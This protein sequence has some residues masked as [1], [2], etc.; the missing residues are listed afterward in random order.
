[1]PPAAYNT[2][3]AYDT[4]DGVWSSDGT[5]NGT[6]L[7]TQLPPDL[8]I[9]SLRRPTGRAYDD[10]LIFEALD[11]VH[12]VRQ[13]WRTDGT[14]AGTFQ[15]GTVYVE[16]R[17]DTMH[18]FRSLELLRWTD[19]RLIY[20]GTSALH[21]Q[22]IYQTDLA[23]TRSELLA[24]FTARATLSSQPHDFVTWHDHVYFLTEDVRN[25]TALWQADQDGNDVQMIKALAPTGRSGDLSA[26]QDALYFFVEEVDGWKQTLWHSDGTPAGTTP[27]LDLWHRSFNSIPDFRYAGADFVTS[28]NAL[29]IRNDNGECNIWEFTAAG[30]QPQT[31]GADLCAGSFIWGNGTLYFSTHQG[32]VYAAE[33]GDMGRLHT[34]E[35]PA[36][37]DYFAPIYA[38][39]GALY[40]VGE[41]T[42]DWYQTES[43]LYGCA[44]RRRKC[45]GVAF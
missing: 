27:L 16:N 10:L 9:E 19:G 24:G 25:G 20:T 5:P 42:N 13:L 7:I 40:L 2:A 14:A 3:G 17:D 6:T 37:F 43:Y 28:P 34:I 41:T 21:G 23:L 35:R 39:D 45:K 38:A 4:V 30:N 32:H 29:Y 12:Q 26:T 31:L 33:N 1:M 18:T 8:R 15:I 11:Q 36:N 44:R 22:Q